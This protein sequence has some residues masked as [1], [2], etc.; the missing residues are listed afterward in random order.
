MHSRL[1]PALAKAYC[2]TY[3]RGLTPDRLLTRLGAGPGR[4]EL[5]LDE[6]IRGQARGAVALGEW[7][8]LVE[9]YGG[10]GS[11][12]EVVLP[13]SAGTRL[14]SHS[15]LDVDDMDHFHWVDD[16]RIRFQFL[17][18]EG[19]SHGIVDGRIRFLF[20]PHESYCGE[21][22]DEIADLLEQMHSPVHPL[23]EQPHRGPAFSLAERLTGIT[24][25]PRLLEESRYLTAH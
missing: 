16:G 6:L 1:P 2:L 25:T 8:L 20:R 15:Y 7:A 19:Y 3:V 12:E 13:L 23:P 9:S 4:A 14:V 17:P 11:T 22:P 10:L 18:E 21:P 5:T 24:M